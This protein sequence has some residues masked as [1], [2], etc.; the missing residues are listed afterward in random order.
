MVIE[1]K[2]VPWGGAGTCEADCPADPAW[3]CK[4]EEHREEE[5]MFELQECRCSR[6]LEKPY[7]GRAVYRDLTSG[8][9]SSEHLPRQECLR[10]ETE[11]SGGSECR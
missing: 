8:M 11:H 3:A 1:W 6:V 10:S 9:H 5:E 4:Y 2:M 7:N